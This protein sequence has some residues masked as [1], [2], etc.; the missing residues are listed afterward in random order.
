MPG[1]AKVFTHNRFLAIWSMLHCVNE[2]NPAVNK[3]DK[4]YKSRP[5]FDIIVANLT[6]LR[7]SL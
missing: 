7:A 1:F 4:I 6:T 2:Q 5:I 3:M